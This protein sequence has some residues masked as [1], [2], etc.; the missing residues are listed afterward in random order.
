MKMFPISRRSGAA[1]L[2]SGLLLSSAVGQTV[3]NATW[4]GD[5]VNNFNNGAWSDS[6]KWNPMQ[7]PNNNGATVFDVTLPYY[8]GVAQF[9]GPS[10][11][12]DVTIRNLTIVNR[13]FLDN[14]GRGGTNL[15]VTGTTSITTSPGHDG[16]T[17]ALFDA[18][19]TWL[20][21]T[22]TNY[23][24]AT[25]TFNDG[26]F[27]PFDNSTIGFRGADIVTNK[28]TIIMG[29]AAARLIDQDTNQ[30]AL[31]NLAVNMGGL[32]LSN[33]YN[34][35]VPA[36]T[37]NGGI[38]IEN[39]I[40]TSTTFTVTSNLTNYDTASGT[41]TD[42][43]Y[44]VQVTDLPGTA[45]FRFANANIRQLNNAQIT[46]RGAGASI[47]DLG[48]QNALR[49][50]TGLQ[51]G[52]LTSAGTLTMTPQ[53]GTFTNNATTH[54]IDSGANIT[55]QGNHHS[56]GGNTNIGQP[57]DSSNTTLIITG[58]SIIEGGGLDMGGQ[59]GVN[60][61]YHTQ[62]QVMNGIQFRGA[63][64]TGTGTTFADI[65]LIQGSVFSPGHSP[66]QVTIE[67][68]LSI[69]TSST[70]QIQIGGII[71]GEEFDQVVQHGTGLVTVGGTLDL[72][73]INGFETSVMHTDS[74]DIVTSD[75]N[76]AGAFS[77]VASGGRL[78]TSDGLGSFKVTYANQKTVTLSEFQPTLRLVSAVAR[79][80]HGTMGDFDLP[81]NLTG[82]G[83][84]IEPRGGTTHHI[85]LTFSN[86]I[87]DGSFTVSAP[88]G[89]EVTSASYSGNTVV[90][91]LT[92]VANAQVVT[93]HADN[94]F[95]EYAQELSG[96]SFDI[97]FLI[98]DVNSDGYVNSADATITRSR[99]GHS[100]DAT[101]YRAD[102]NHD[103][104]VNSA[105][106]TIVRARSG[107]TIFP[108]T[109]P[110]RVR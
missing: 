32:T 100:T 5:G 34:L 48:G 27:F 99:S 75:N 31:R 22:L 21:G 42:G 70:L 29:G 95:D 49:N 17:A 24:A 66:G 65:G 81:L 68:A 9:N 110:N 23:N 6:S 76:I 73:L 38:S 62:L 89:G 40:G 44:N 14:Q 36:F 71:A 98:G 85:V 79:E 67:G 57:T 35:T 15:T 26:F 104:S 109:E 19:G 92:G 54:N 80:T 10:L 84:A 108:G 86:S 8:P 33:G 51:G 78:A 69:D 28:G 94:V 82:G 45:T 52:T 61:Q 101:N 97:G 74:F 47:Q 1:L 16:E 58:N 87:D 96:A 46:L 3:T 20:L 2:A 12:I 105:D 91:T 60:T 41:L 39:G 93:F 56:T 53:G 107:T 4:L 25:H 106:A 18:G 11:D 90:V 103:G 13:L 88:A 83:L 7:V 59:P 72:S 102:A 37:N 55:I 63:Y 43:S 64:L 77:N 30:N 50:L